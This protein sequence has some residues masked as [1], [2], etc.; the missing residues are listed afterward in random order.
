MTMRK[1]ILFTAAAAVS[2]LSLPASAHHGW[3]GNVDQVTEMTGMVVESVKLAGPHATMRID[4]DGKT[5]DLTLAAPAR[6]SSSG[7]KANAIP[8]GSMVTVVGN[9]NRNPQR[10]EMKTIQVRW[11]DKKYTVYPERQAYLR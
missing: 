4:A 11:G 5:W 9:K 7:L 3:G 8:V 10:F 2:F 1:H 6:T